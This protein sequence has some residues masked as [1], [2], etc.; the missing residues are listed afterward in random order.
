[1]LEVP[2]ILV[3]FKA[4]PSAIGERAA[5]LARVVESVGNCLLYTS[6]SPRDS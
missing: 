4:Y 1:M 3:N 2:L 6:P 5:E